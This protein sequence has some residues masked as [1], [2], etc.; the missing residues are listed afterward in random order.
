M[1]LVNIYNSRRTIYLFCR[2]ER[3]ILTIK[4]DTGF[5][6]YYYEPDQMGEYK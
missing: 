5:F 2:D 6:P 3:G 4:K 1:K